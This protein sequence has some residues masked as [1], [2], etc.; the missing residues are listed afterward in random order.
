MYLRLCF[1]WRSKTT[2]RVKGKGT[3]QWF[4]SR[5]NPSW[6]PS[7][8]DPWDSFVM[9][10]PRIKEFSTGHIPHWDLTSSTYPYDKNKKH[11]NVNWLK[12]QNLKSYWAKKIKPILSQPLF[13]RIF[14]TNSLKFPDNKYFIIMCCIKPNI[15]TTQYLY[16]FGL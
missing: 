1:S 12:T 14:S 5:C 2:W 15:V 4:D 16:S 9:A 11:A 3:P 10:K 7:H 13:H 6:Q 8:L